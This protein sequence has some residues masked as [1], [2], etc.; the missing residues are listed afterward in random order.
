MLIQLCQHVLLQATVPCPVHTLASSATVEVRVAVVP[1]L[2]PA[3]IA[4]S[5]VVDDVVAGAV[6]AAARSTPRCVNG[7]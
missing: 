7:A 1:V 6:A 4:S 3:H 2:A 5:V